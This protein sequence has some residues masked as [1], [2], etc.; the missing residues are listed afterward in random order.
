MSQ[1]GEQRLGMRLA[2]WMLVSMP[3]HG[4]LEKVRRDG[5]DENANRHYP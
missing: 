2:G 3:K 5:A 4:P 1:P